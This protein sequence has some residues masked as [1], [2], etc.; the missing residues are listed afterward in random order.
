MDP[1]LPLLFTADQTRARGLSRHRVAHRVALGRWT[2]LRRGLY[3]V[4]AAYDALDPPTQHLV[5]V[6]AALRSRGHDVLASHLSAACAYVWPMPAPGWGPPTLTSADLDI[7]VRR[8]QRLVLQVASVR[9]VDRGIRSDLPVTSP[10]RT[11]A[12]VLRHQPAQDSVPIADAALRSGAT[13]SEQVWRVLEWQQA[14]PYVV[15]ARASLELVDQRRETWIESWSFVRLHQHGV[16]LPE[17]QVEV[18]DA[19][20]RFVAR[21]DALW[22]GAT[23]GE[24]D[25]R[26]K[27]LLRGPHLA[28]AMPDVAA[29]RVVEE[30]Q[31]RLDAEKARRD[32]LHDV[33]LEVVR[34]GYAELARDPDAVVR[35]VQARR[36]AA[37]P[38]RFTGRLR[39]RPPDWTAP[40]P[41]PR[42]PVLMGDATT[43]PEQAT[44]WRSS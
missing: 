15:R 10:A 5:Q 41:P 22:D 33:G 27:Y 43:A 28:G 1:D 30:A 4:A 44:S 12:D 7:P 14:W 24:A 13:T 39:R 18:L 37:D 20:G 21:G 23:L 2:S 42:W 29:E 11:V 38:A 26:V 8:S 9:P 3:C 25:G 16:P 36:A 17:P 6:A 34:W 19:R 35:R 32:A 40:A 31:R